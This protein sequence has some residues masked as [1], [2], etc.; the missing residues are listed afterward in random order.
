MPAPSFRRTET[1]GGAGRTVNNTHSHSMTENRECRGTTELHRYIQ[2]RVILQSVHG[3]QFMASRVL[4]AR[5]A[6]GGCGECV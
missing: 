3:S 6:H 5:G 4:G 1:H 2:V